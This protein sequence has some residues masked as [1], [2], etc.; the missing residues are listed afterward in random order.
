MLPI[1]K[2][3]TIILLIYFKIIIINISISQSSLR[4]TIESL[5]MIGGKRMIHISVPKKNDFPISIHY[6]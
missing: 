5:P 3:C 4:N 2:K 6:P 1:L